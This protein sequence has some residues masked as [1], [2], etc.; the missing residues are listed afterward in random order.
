MTLRHHLCD[1]PFYDYSLFSLRGDVD[2]FVL[3]HLLSVLLWVEDER[4][5]PDRSLDRYSDWFEIMR[6]YIVLA[7]RRESRNE[8]WGGAK[9][10]LQHLLLVYG[11]I[12]PQRVKKS[13]KSALF[14]LS[15]PQNAMRIL[16][17]QIINKERGLSE[18]H[19]RT[20]RRAFQPQCC[21]FAVT[22]VT[23]RMKN[24]E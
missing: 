8:W 7:L 23:Q 12:S 17:N 19:A 1:N 14:S 3:Q 13:R 21:F 15:T 20:R 24:G 10:V 2:K 6:R 11:E 9:H 4:I 5:I 22:S 18:L 16:Q